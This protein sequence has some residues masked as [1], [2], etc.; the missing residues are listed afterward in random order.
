MNNGQQ[1]PDS[2]T[3]AQRL[4]TKLTELHQLIGASAMLWVVRSEL[5]ERVQEADDKVR[6]LSQEVQVLQNEVRQEM[7]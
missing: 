6:R 4:V 2:P 1:P 5:E 7:S 3:P